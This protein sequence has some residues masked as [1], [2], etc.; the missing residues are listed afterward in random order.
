MTTYNL[1]E[2]KISLSTYREYYIKTLSEELPEDLYKKL[3][4]DKLPIQDFMKILKDNNYHEITKWHNSLR[5]NIP[6]NEIISL[7]KNIIE[8][9][10][11]MLDEIANLKDGEHTY[12]TTLGRMVKFY[13]QVEPL[14]RSV[15]FISDVSPFKIIRD[16]STK[17]KTMLEEESINSESRKDVYESI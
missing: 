6:K 7:A 4:E 14:T 13:A 8:A 10:K 3:L 11:T 1:E 9:Q 17:A 5:W 12:D 15:G 16:A 2:E